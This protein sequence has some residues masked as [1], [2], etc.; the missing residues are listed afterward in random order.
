[1]T[2]NIEK[3][4]NMYVFELNSCAKEHWFKPA[5]GWELSLATDEE[6]NAIEK[7]YK[8]THATTGLP[9]TLLQLHGL[10][11][12]RL[13]QSGFNNNSGMINNATTDLKYLIAYNPER[14][15]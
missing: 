13:V 9:E 11:K 10:V 2:S 1:M 7:K 6:R 15:R 14:L 4:A 12:S 3:Q 5:E 8:P